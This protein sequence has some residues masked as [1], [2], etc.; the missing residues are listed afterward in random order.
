MIAHVVCAVELLPFP[1]LSVYH[2]ASRIYSEK[3]CA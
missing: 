1:V 2:D 3:L